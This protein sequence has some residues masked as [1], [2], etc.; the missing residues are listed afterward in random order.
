MNSAFLHHINQQLIK[1]IQEKYQMDNATVL[2]ISEA[3]KNSVM[4]SLK[5]FVLK[6]GTGEIEGILLN[7]TSF[8]GSALQQL[9]FANF[10]KDIADKKL[11]N[12]QQTHEVAEFS[13]NFLIDQFKSGFANSGHS[14]DLDGICK[15]LEIDKKLI[16]IANSPVTKFFGKLF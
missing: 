11:L 5:Q 7:K 14:K 8:N 9:S 10:Q 6:N 12:A 4:A 3:G 15:F 13:I 2:N 1:A 16:Q